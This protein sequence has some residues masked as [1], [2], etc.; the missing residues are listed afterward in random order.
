LQAFDHGAQ[1]P[2]G[3]ARGF[4]GLAQ[5]HTKNLVTVSWPKSIDDAIERTLH[6]RGRRRW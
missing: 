2:L 4:K 6:R 1:S 5:E 3:T